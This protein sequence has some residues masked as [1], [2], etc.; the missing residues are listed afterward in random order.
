VEGLNIGGF[1]LGFLGIGVLGLTSLVALGLLIGRKTTA[2]RIVFAA[3]LLSAAVIVAVAVLSFLDSQFHGNE[4]WSQIVLTALT[5]LLSGTGQFVAALRKPQ[6][7][8]AALACAV[9]A[10]V[11]LPTLLQ[12][13]FVARVISARDLNPAAVRLIQAL[14]VLLALASLMIALFPRQRR[15]AVLWTAQALLGAI[16]GFVVGDAGLATRCTILAEEGRGTPVIVEVFI[17]GVR[18]SE[19]TGMV[20]VPDAGTSSI[21]SLSSAQAA[22]VHGTPAAGAVA[23]IIAALGM[24]TLLVRQPAACNRST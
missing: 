20:G 13:D 2:A 22:W 11:L 7:Y 4:V 24:A 12:G 23:G 5:L 21:R 1:L 9:G 3:G 18:V 10:V 16:A 14:S 17:L 15:G 6:T 19:E 8:G